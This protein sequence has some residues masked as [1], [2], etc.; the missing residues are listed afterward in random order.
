MQRMEFQISD[1]ERSDV[2]ASGVNVFR[3]QRT[4][5]VGAGRA[6]PTEWYLTKLEGGDLQHT[7]HILFR[8]LRRHAQCQL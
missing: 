2:V 6:D 1:L 3:V 5:S 8:E 7:Y 4:F